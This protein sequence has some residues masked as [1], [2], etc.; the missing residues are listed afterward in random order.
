MC[1]FVIHE[2][3]NQQ[4]CPPLPGCDEQTTPSVYYIDN[5]LIK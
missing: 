5:V 4:K 3:P 2:T 1:N